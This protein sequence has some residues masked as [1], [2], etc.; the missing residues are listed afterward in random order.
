M[1]SIRTTKKLVDLFFFI[2]GETLLS[3]L[4]GS[5]G[6]GIPASNIVSWTVANN[7]NGNT[8]AYYNFSRSFVTVTFIAGY[9]NNFYEVIGSVSFCTAS[10]P[11]YRQI[12]FPYYRG[13]EYG[14]SAYMII[15][16]S[17]LTFSAAELTGYFIIV[18]I[19]LL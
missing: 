16:N 2:M 5:N 9:Q 17:N 8:Y 7:R 19:A 14:A 18:E 6:S 10:L 13:N 1:I 15:N 4:G 11:A 12:A 3:R